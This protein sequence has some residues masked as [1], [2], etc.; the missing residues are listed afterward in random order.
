MKNIIQHNQAAWDAES[1]SASEWCTPVSTEEI[2]Q[3][4]SG[5][6]DVV[7]TPN[8]SVP[9]HWFGDISGKNILC[10]ASGGGQQAPI[11][12][13]A[14]A[15]VTSYDLSAAQLLKDQQVASRDS[16]NITTIQG[17]MSHLDKLA[18]ATF[19]LIF[20]PVSNV[21]VPEIGPVWR[22]AYR[23]LK[24]AGRLLSG[25]LNP[26]YFLFDHEA[27][28]ESQKLMAQFAAPYTEPNSL[29]KSGQQ[30]LQKSGR[31]YEFGHSLESQIGG[32]IAAGFT[33][34]GFYEDNWNDAATP[35]NRLSPTYVATLA[36]K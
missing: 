23:V 9:R 21:F 28:T 15:K 17:D 7:L 3:A 10:L 4:K 31:A 2:H 35:L 33:I 1:K 24:P 14:G 13:A 6:W 27:E 19:D 34:S 36:I 12:A 5:N 8:R 29:S 30:A 26:S 16:L 25:F 20:H 22:E 18:D 11:L 32:Q